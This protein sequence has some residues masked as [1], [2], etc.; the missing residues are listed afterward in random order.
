MR[1]SYV[2]SLYEYFSIKILFGEKYQSP[3][4]SSGQAIFHDNISRDCEIYEMI[5]G[6]EKKR[7]DINHFLSA[8]F[9]HP[10]KKLRAIIQ[11]ITNSPAHHMPSYVPAPP[12]LDLPFQ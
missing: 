10:N 5:T 3:Y 12:I 2:N 8:S 1:I 4:P 6:I 9:Y 7:M 11:N